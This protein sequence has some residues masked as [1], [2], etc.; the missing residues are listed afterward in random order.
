MIT[1]L[2]RFGKSFI[3]LLS[4]G[5][6]PV[7]ESA[8]RRAASKWPGNR[9]FTERGSNGAGQGP[10][11]TAGPGRR[12]RRCQCLLAGLL[13]RDLLVDQGEVDALAAADVAGRQVHDD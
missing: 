5:G 7:R 12:T 13:D 8:A 11:Q 10:R 9:S 2:A 4:A 1:A 6:V 3:A